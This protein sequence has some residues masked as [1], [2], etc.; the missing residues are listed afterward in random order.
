MKTK[1]YI[2]VAAL[3]LVLSDGLYWQHKELVKVK[4]ERNTYK[5]NMDGLLTDI[6]RLETDSTKNAIQVQSLNLKVDEYK[7]YCAEDAATIQ[8]LNIKL[9]NVQ[10]V[11]KSEIGVEVPIQ[12][13]VAHD[14]IYIDNI[15]KPIQ[16]I[17]YDDDYAK[18]E[19]TI[20]DDSLKASIHIPITL[21]QV[22]H[23]VPKHKFLWWSWGCKAI[24]Q[25]IT[26]DNPYADIKYL[27]Y[28]EINKQ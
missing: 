7:K 12:T 26:S 8:S 14:T 22:V 19:G 9:K 21:T 24:K 2:G 3:I 10:S 27:E 13:L 25:A 5:T 15:I 17:N 16:T 28:I 20:A 23:K 4:A 18:L 6:E 1:I 11:S